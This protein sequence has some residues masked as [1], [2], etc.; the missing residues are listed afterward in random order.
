MRRGECRCRDQGQCQGRNPDNKIRSRRR[1]SVH[2]SACYQGVE[3]GSSRAFTNPSPTWALS[4]PFSTLCASEPSV[5]SISS[6]AYWLGLSSLSA[7]SFLA[8][9][10]PTPIPQ[11][12]VS[13]RRANVSRPDTMQRNSRFHSWRSDKCCASIASSS[14]GIRSV[15]FSNLPL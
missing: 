13:S 1:I 3:I 9:G 7:G 6:K 8:D 2:S 5:S 4:E 11:C 12:S 10:S 14:H 15:E